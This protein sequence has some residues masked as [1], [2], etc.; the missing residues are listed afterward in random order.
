MSIFPGI[1]ISSRH[2]FHRLFLLHICCR[3]RSQVQKL[4]VTYPWHF[5][6]TRHTFHARHHHNLYM[7]RR[8]LAYIQDMTL[9]FLCSRNV[10]TPHV[11]EIHHMFEGAVFI[12]NLYTIK[13]HNPR[14]SVK[15]AVQDPRMNITYGSQVPRVKWTSKVWRGTWSQVPR[16]NFLLSL[17]FGSMR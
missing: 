13:S 14:K 7:F 3:W 16:M 6:C 15:C 8:F 5:I 4:K 12:H 2:L 11:P 10:Q 1:T 17:E 9:Y